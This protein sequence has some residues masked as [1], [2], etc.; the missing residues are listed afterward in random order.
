MG[1]RTQGLAGPEQA[2][3]VGNVLGFPVHYCKSLGKL[4][5]SYKHDLMTFGHNNGFQ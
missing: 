1:N 5:G 3:I 4:L 2:R